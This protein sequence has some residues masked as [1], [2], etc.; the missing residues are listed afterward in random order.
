VQGIMTVNVDLVPALITE[1]HFDE[2]DTSP[3]V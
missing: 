2:G 3:D 1:L